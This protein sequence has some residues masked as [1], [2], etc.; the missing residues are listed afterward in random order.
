MEAKMVQEGRKINYTPA[1][2][3]AAGAI[4]ELGGLVG[5]AE[6]PIAANAIGALNLEG[7]FDVLKDG[8]AGPVFAIGDHVFWDSV[9]SLAVRTGGSGCWYLGTCVDLAAGTNDATVRTRLA[10]HHLPAALQDKLWED[11][12]LASASKTLDIQDVGKVMNVTVGHATNVV[13]LPAIAAGL[14]FV[15]RCGTTGQRVAISPQ[16][17]D[18]IM[19]AD[20][21]GANDKDR[22]LAAATSRKGD[23]CALE[24]GSADGYLVRAERGVWAAE[25]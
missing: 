5:V 22:I 24:Y 6:R 17:D 20:L 23:Y 15:V 11:V 7:V 3:V 21:A 4:V 19:G 12:T 2:D 25:A 8:T 14:A 9:N 16:A 1:A 10:P 18:K 13:V